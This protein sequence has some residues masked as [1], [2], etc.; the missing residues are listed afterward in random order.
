MTRSQRWTESLLDDVTIRGSGHTPSQSRPDFWDGDIPWVSLADSDQLDSGYIRTTR[1]NISGRGLAGSSAVLHP[2]RTV[3]LSRDAGVGKSAVLATPMAVSQHFIAWQCDARGVIDP[4]FLYYVLQRQKP[5]FGRMAVGSTIKT[6]GLPLFRKLRISYPSLSEQRKI[7]EILRTWDEAI[8]A[9]SRLSALARSRRD[10][11]RQHLYANV[12]A[13][14]V[15][16]ASI[17]TESRLP[18]KPETSPQKITIRLYGRG[19]VAKAI[20]QTSAATRYFERRAGQ[21]VYSKL[22]FLNGAFA[23]VPDELNGF[24]TT[25]DLPAFDIDDQ[26]NPAW[27]INYLTRP[28]YYE[29]QLHLARGQRKARRVNPREFLAEVIA[30]PS[31][32]HQ[33]HTADV[34]ASADQEIA[35]LDRKIEL[36]RAQKRGLAERLLSGELRVEAGEPDD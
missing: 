25:L 16:I 13:E 29:N 18:G 8:D 35:L 36:L 31:S 12:P 34:L 28:S 4:W 9:T 6:I 15:T 10:R 11:L 23:I 14:R 17:L 27:L 30:L 22:D 26:V 3:I 7:A 2:A 24:E 33:A 21:L 1:R 19:A 5:Y 32:A 20:S